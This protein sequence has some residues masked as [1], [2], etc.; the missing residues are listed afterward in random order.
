[1]LAVTAM[2]RTRL[3]KICEGSG[4]ICFRSLGIPTENGEIHDNRRVL[5]F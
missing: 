3:P 2:W 5:P 1:M 4:L